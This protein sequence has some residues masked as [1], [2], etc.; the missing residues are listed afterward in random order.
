VPMPISMKNSRSSWL[1]CS[2]ASVV[3]GVDAARLMTGAPIALPGT[4]EFGVFQSFEADPYP[5]LHADSTWR[6]HA[7]S[8]RVMSPPADSDE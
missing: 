3:T 1:R 7:G 6:P 5:P 2:V 8:I 4:E